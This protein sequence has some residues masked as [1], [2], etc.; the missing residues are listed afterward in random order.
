MEPWW[1]AQS[2]GE[3][4]FDA[5]RIASRENMEVRCDFRLFGCDVI[6]RPIA[7]PRPP[8]TYFWLGAGAE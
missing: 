3:I 7:A 8:A 1:T 2:C 5:A 6:V 4:V